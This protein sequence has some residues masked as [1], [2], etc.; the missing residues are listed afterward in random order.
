MTS[1][2]T[3]VGATFGMIAGCLLLSACAADASG[4][5]AL[6]PERAVA[7]EATVVVHLSGLLM[8]IPPQQDGGR[9][10]VLLPAA[11]GH[12]A[13]MGFGIAGDEAF[14]QRLCMTDE[15]HGLPAIRAGVCYVDMERW[16]LQPLG[17]GG[18]PPP[19]VNT[20]PA[21]LLSASDAA[22]GEYRVD[23]AAVGGDL[24]A[25]VALTAG[26]V[27]GQ[28]SLASWVVDKVDAAGAPRPRE[29]LPLVNVLS[30]EIRNPA[31]TELVFHSRSG[32]ETVTVPLPAPAPNGKIEILLTHVPFEELAD[33]PP[34]MPATLAPAPDTAYHFAALYDLLRKDGERLAPDSPRRR[35]PHTPSQ[36][37]P[38][39]CD[40]RITT[41]VRHTAQ[42]LP[43]FA[44]NLGVVG[45]FRAFR[46]PD[47][48]PVRA[49]A[50]TT[51]RMGGSAIGCIMGGG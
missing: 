43:S 8:V 13:R 1:R 46:S 29:V 42:A 22:G 10:H 12:V 37:S 47:A 51:V 9:T 15:T 4:A 39:S 35:L 34:A 23:V 19:A 16:A 27:G 36:L 41:P 48:H 26:E 17:D 33:L 18:P 50:S 2:G 5:H 21:G 44:D 45:G 20:L 49:R 24:R 28:C 14:V 11:P 40:V 38:H 30:W 7:A 25:Q 31:A 6:I 32:P 3:T